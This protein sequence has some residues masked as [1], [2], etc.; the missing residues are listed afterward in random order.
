MKR[1][2]FS[3]LSRRARNHSDDSRSCRSLFAPIAGPRANDRIVFGDATSFGH[4]TPA[5]ARA[6]LDARL[7]QAQRR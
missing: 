6:I 5:A 7:E 3:K 2:L 1:V 4:A